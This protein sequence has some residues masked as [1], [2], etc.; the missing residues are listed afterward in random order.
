MLIVLT[1]LRIVTELAKEDVLDRLT[2]ATINK[3]SSRFAHLVLPGV[4][5]VLSTALLVVLSTAESK[6]QALLI[7]VALAAVALPSMIRAIGTPANTEVRDCTF[8]GVTPIPQVLQRPPDARRRD[9][10]V[11]SEILIGHI[12]PVLQFHPPEHSPSAFHGRSRLRARCLCSSG[13]DD[14]PG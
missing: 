2:N 3:A 13:I 7:P 4:L 14:T 8:D 6:E 9:A 12:G 1:L 5:L 10:L 11:A